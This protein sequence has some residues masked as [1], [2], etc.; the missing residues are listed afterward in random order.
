M[1]F[2]GFRNAFIRLPCQILQTGRKI[3]YRLLGWSPR[4]N[5]FLR[6]V[7]SLRDPLRC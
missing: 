1:E 7:D 5:V 4:L 6:A 2:K 3:V